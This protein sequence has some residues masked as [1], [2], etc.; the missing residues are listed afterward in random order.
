ME[1]GDTA[2]EEPSQRSGTLACGVGLR[3]LPESTIMRERAVI[4]EALVEGRRA[5]GEQ[6]DAPVAHQ[7]HMQLEIV[8]S[9][10]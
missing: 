2:E 9:D 10:S 4:S 3:S 5:D 1:M 6:N 8:L 7:A